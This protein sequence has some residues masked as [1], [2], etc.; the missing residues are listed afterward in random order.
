MLKKLL[1]STVCVLSL[2]SPAFAICGTASYY[3]S[4]TITASGESFNP[5][6]NTVAH[7]YLPFGTRLK[8]VNQRNGL[9]AY[10][11]VRDRGP[12]VGGRTL[13]LSLGLFRKIESTER[14]LANVCYY[15]Y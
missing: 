12:Y 11:V 4:G 1:A 7:P 13:D 6:G 15:K 5:Y 9:V 8:I 2:S 3:Q 10:G 14:G